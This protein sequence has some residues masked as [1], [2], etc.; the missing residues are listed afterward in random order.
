MMQLRW[1]QGVALATLVVVMT[2]TP[3]ETANAQSVRDQQ[4]GSAK[5]S[6]LGGFGGLVIYE[7][8][9]GRGT[10]SSFT[11]GAADQP[12]WTMSFSM[13][14]NY[15]LSRDR[16]LLRLQLRV[17]MDIN[18]IENF[19]SL[20]TRPS[21]TRLRDI[22]IVLQWINFAQFKPA[23]LSW[24]AFF[25]IGIPT[26]LLSQLETRILQARVDLNTVWTPAR[27]LRINYFFSIYRNFHRYAN[28]VVDTSDFDLP[29][30]TRSNGAEALGG[31][32][33]ATGVGNPEWQLLH[34][35][36]FTFA[37]KGFYAA[38]NWFLLQTY[39]YQHF[40]KD[41]QASPYGVDGRAR[42]DLMV[43]AIELGYSVNRS[44]TIALGSST[45]QS[46][47]TANNQS[48]RFPFWDTTNGS[49]NRQTFYL[50]LVGSF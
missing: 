32:L 48:V 39:G 13:W 5:A 35:V 9:I 15:T 49:A 16:G 38:F 21:D 4:T 50:D 29:P 1:M 28:R 19:N 26:S 14:P 27:W 43:G 41:S 46:P 37:A 45:L 33:L 10:F 25:R 12:L 2:M 47:L 8:S 42:L 34:G 18:I 31:A 20:N 44:F 7:N 40:S 30:S 6:P 24:S 17:G 11:D 22:Q 36:G 3:T 23:N